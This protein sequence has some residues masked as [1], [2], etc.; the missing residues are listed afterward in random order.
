MNWTEFLNWTLNEV[1]QWTLERWTKSQHFERELLNWIIFLNG[2][3]PED[4]SLSIGLTY[5][6]I[7]N[8]QSLFLKLRR[9]LP[10][11][12]L[13]PRRHRLPEQHLRA[14]PWI[15]QPLRLLRLRLR[16]RR[17]YLQGGEGLRGRLPA[18]D[19]PWELHPEGHRADVGLWRHRGA[20][21]D[22]RMFRHLRHTSKK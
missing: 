13:D 19:G 15:P 11:L 16:L 2:N 7:N 22:R 6:D 18:E 5:N 3:K 1:N 20:E 4:N 8:W 17:H 9:V 10:V 12:H 14:E 21:R